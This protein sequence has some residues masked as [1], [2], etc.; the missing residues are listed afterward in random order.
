MTEKVK[1]SFNKNRIIV[2]GCKKNMDVEIKNLPGRLISKHRIDKRGL[3]D[4][5]SKELSK[6]IYFVKVKDGLIKY[7]SKI[8][9]KLNQSEF[10]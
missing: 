3:I 4:I 6:G 5:P 2:T 10:L 1:V 8:I 7:S 9:I